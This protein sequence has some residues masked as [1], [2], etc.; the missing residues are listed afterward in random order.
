MGSGQ[1]SVLG[2]GR[3]RGRCHSR[4]DGVAGPKSFTLRLKKG[5]YRFFCDRHA[6]FMHGAFKVG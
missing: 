3:V 2:R 1:Y 5:S 6:S 4:R